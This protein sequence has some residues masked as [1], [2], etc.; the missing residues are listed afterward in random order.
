MW[1]LATSAPNREAWISFVLSALEIEHRIFYVRIAGVIKPIFPGYVFVDA[2]DFDRVRGVTGIRGFVKVDGKTVDVTHVVEKLEAEGRGTNVLLREDAVSSRFQCGDRVQ[3]QGSDHLVFGRVGQFQ[4][5]L[6]NGKASV[7]LPWFNGVMVP[8]VIE[9]SDLEPVT[10][11]SHRSRN[12]R[13][14]APRG[15]S[16]SST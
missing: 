5:Q 15:S 3:V 7:L 6:D 9:E 13:G 2:Y 1:S 14:R 12:R 8:T 10:V 11:G 4:H 16:L